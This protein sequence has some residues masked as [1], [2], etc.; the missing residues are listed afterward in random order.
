MLHGREESKV[1]LSFSIPSI[2][3]ARV[4]NGLI[5]VGLVPVAEIA[6]QQLSIVSD[7]GIAAIGAVRSILLISRVPMAQIRTLA[8]DKSS[9]TSVELAKV[10]LRER[11]GVRPRLRPEEPMLEQMLAGSDAALVIGDPALRIDPEHLPFEWLDLGLEWYTLTGL[12]MVFAAWAGKPERVGDDFDD[13]ARSSC[14]FGR[15]RLS[16]IVQSEFGRRGISKVLATEYFAKYIRFTL[17]ANERR[18][19]EAFTELAELEPSR[20]VKS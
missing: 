17:G 14:Y 15:E 3:A 16:E 13:L 6:R 9:R 18:G 2:C 12:P 20:S 4:E 11:F 5:D 19:L 7:V 10:I 1:D 8:V